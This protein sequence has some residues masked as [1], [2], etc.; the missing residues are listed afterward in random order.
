[1][2][3]KD[4]VHG[5]MTP[6]VT[7]FTEREDLDEAAFRREVGLMLDLGVHGLVVGGSTGE[8]HALTPEELGRLTIVA[9]S[10]ARGNVPVV[11]GVITTCTRDAVRRGRVAKEAGADGLMVT[12]IIY[13]VPSDDG[14][15]DYYDRIWREVGLPL[16][17]YNV[18]PR[19]PVSPRLLRRLVSIEG[20][21]GIKESI[22]G[23][24]DTLSEM[25]RT[26]GDKIS[27]TWAQDPLLFAGFALGAT[28]SISGIN[29][30]LPQLSLDLW[31]AVERNDLNTARKIHYRMLPVAQAMGLDNWPARVKELVNLQGRNV[32]PARRPFIPVTEE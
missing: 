17:I 15:F 2:L 6:L 12:P 25:V 20:L 18:V 30:V 24:L 1:M 29:A 31:H 5:I 16:I 27:V 10:E 14:L 11:A 22:G 8:G 32:G 13:Q 7:P 26:V 19:V 4:G 21:V 28:G 9:A 3:T 23:N